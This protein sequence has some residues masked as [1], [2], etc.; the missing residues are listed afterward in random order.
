MPYLESVTTVYDSSVEFSGVLPG[1]PS[2][3]SGAFG[4]L[5]S[6]KGALCAGSL[7]PSM[8]FG[9]NVSDIMEQ[10]HNARVNVRTAAAI[11]IF[12]ISTPVNQVKGNA[13]HLCNIAL[14]TFILLS[15]LKQLFN[16]IEEAGSLLIVCRIA[17]LVKFAEDLFLLLSQIFRNLNRNPDVLVASAA[18]IQ[19]LYTL[20][21]ELEYIS[22]L[23]S[24]MNGIA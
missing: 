10:P 19:V 8:G 12:F 20:A 13:A 11:F 4:G 3:L 22:G 17:G 23:G 1:A 15:I 6:S 7:G 5:F 2:G 18:G 9:G 16:L 24:R 14:V 21:L